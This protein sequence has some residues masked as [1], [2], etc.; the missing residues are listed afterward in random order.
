MVSA[1]P[2]R[3][4]PFL[5]RAFTAADDHVVRSVATSDGLELRCPDLARSQVFD[6][7]PSAEIVVCLARSD[8]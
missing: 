3:P 7:H 8:S 2:G 6:S 5:Y 1:V 4:I